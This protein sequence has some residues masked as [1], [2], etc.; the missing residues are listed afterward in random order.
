MSSAP[1]R[2][3]PRIGYL[4]FDGHTSDFPCAIRDYNGSSATLVLNGWL[5]IPK[6]FL[7]Y[8]EPEGMRFSCTIT[9]RRGNS[10]Q[11]ALS[12]GCSESRPRARN[13]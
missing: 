9:G 8:V 12:D 2:R 5:G 4:V 11:V 6:S 1:T 7:L 13:R 10:V 3:T